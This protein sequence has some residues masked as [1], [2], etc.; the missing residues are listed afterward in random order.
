LDTF[1]IIRNALASSED[2]ASKNGLRPD[3]IE[4]GRILTAVQTVV[5]A[6][7][8]PDGGRYVV[9]FA[10]IQTAATLLGERRIIVSSKPLQDR[11]LSMVEKA[12]VIAT[13][14]A[15]EIGHTLVTRPRGMR[16]EQHN[17]KSGYHA[18]A[19]VADDIILEPFM[20][21]RYPILR[22]AFDFTGLWVLRNT[23]KSL[24]V[25]PKMRRDM[26]TPE[27]FNVI[28][29]ATRY[30]DT[31]EIIWDG[32]AQIAER[33]WARQ[34]AGGLI[35]LRLNDHDGFLA[36]C[37]ALWARIRG[38]AD[39]D[40]Q[41]PEPI[42]DQPQPTDETQPGE[43]DEDEDGDDGEDGDE[44]GDESEPGDEQGEDEGEGGSDESDEDGE[45]GE[46]GT[47]P[48]EGEGNPDEQGDGEDWDDAKD[49]DEPGEDES[50]GTDGSG[51]SDEDIGEDSDAIGTD[52]ADG[53]SEDA[54]GNP[55]IPDDADGGGGNNTANDAPLRDESDFNEDD[56]EQGMHDQSKRERYDYDGDRAEEIARTYAST[57][58]TSFGRH[59]S[60]S[61]TWE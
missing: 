47:Q 9:A 44:Q 3:H 15:H 38:A 10:D 55:D 50:K 24:P 26:T 7:T 45:D 25:T 46:G 30:G 1:S 23:A 6:L 11:H 41:A 39:E 33:D 12:V 57:S 58:V 13:F 48:G 28:L 27:R 51:E 16:V 17:S 5:D 20:A 22:D 56:V 14:A 34:W 49:G 36:A 8:P 60:I 32:A 54:D 37:D 43:S 31:P 40:E 29:S 21:D 4:T 19:N 35:A 2:D 61:T 59:G 52:P 18:V 42:I 53:N